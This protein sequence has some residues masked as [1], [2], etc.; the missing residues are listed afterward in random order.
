MPALKLLIVSASRNWGKALLARPSRAETTS[1]AR[2]EDQGTPRR[3]PATTKW[4]VL[5]YAIDSTARTVRLGV[6]VLVIAV[7]VLIAL[8]AGVSLF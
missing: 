8:Q 5:K 4:D 2:Q 7:A 6:L 1:A 3:E